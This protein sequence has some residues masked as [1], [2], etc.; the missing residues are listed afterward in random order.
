MI[1]SNLILLISKWI[2]FVKNYF[3]EYRNK[4]TKENPKIAPRV[5]YLF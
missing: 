2:C 3:D 4:N 1:S 5:I